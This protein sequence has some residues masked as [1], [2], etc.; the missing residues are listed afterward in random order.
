MNE[1]GA[2][3]QGC[4]KGAILPRGSPSTLIPAFLKLVGLDTKI[5]CLFVLISV[6]V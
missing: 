3:K 4:Q 1:G 6:N 2:V 5:G